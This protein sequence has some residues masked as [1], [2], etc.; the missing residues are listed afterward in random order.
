V[1]RSPRSEVRGIAERV[2]QPLDGGV[3]AVIELDD[4]VVR[5]ERLADLV[6]QHH[7]TGMVQQHEQDAE[8]LLV[9]AD[10]DTVLAQLGGSSV[11]FER[12]ET[13]RP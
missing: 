13:N 5:P 6:A 4:G 9:K 12:V 10:P 1:P 2:A 7:L 11:Q 3:D 8:G